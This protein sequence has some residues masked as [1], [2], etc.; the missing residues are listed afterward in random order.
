MYCSYFVFRKL[1]NGSGFLSSYNM[2]SASRSF[3]LISL[4]SVFY[5]LI[6]S[7]YSLFHF[8]ILSLLLSKAVANLAVLSKKNKGAQITESLRVIW[9]E[10]PRSYDNEQMSGQVLQLYYQDRCSWDS[11]SRWSATAM[12]TTMSSLTS[13][14]KW[15][16]NRNRSWGN[17]RSKGYIR[18]RGTTG[19]RGTPGAGGQ[20]E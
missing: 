13:S 9:R 7:T 17:I 19:V 8:F 12:A 15:S 3:P 16:C 10:D 14:I 20:Q 18:S 1:C 2:L 6:F 5:S 11:R 4:L